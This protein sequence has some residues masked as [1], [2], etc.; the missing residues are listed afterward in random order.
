MLT[1]ALAMQSAPL[2]FSY[3]FFSLLCVREREWKEGSQCYGTWKLDM[4]SGFYVFG[5][6]F[7]WKL[8]MWEMVCPRIVIWTGKKP[9]SSH[10]Q[11]GPTQSDSALF[12]SLPFIASYALISND[13]PQATA[14]I[15]WKTD[16]LMAISRERG[17]SDIRGIR[18]ARREVECISKRRESPVDWGRVEISENESREWLIHEK[19]STRRLGSEAVQAGAAGDEWPEMRP[20]W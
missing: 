6:L 17:K 5:Q 10:P 12:S 4:G 1:M 13:Y 2:L 7:R 3:S 14:T 8:P 9:F 20:P 19:N 15:G 11:R 16:Y 18:S